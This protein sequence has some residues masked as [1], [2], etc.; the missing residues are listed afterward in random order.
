MFEG[1]DTRKESLIGENENLPVG[2][3]NRVCEELGGIYERAETQKAALDETLNLF[4]SERQSLVN[5]TLNDYV[6]FLVRRFERMMKELLANG[7][8]IQDN[9]LSFEELNEHLHAIMLEIAMIEVK[10]KRVMPNS[11]D[12]TESCLDDFKNLS[13]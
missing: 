12:S 7:E 11:D 6:A 10:I 13:N 5:E 3:V 2:E 4:A 1:F 8:G 9:S